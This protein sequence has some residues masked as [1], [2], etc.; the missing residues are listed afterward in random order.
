M[1]VVDAHQHFWSLPRGDYTWLTPEL[2]ALYRDYLPSDFEPLRERAGVRASVLIQAAASEAE[3]HYLFEIA[4]RHA[5]I[6]AVVGWVDFADAQAAER[7][8]VLT[9]AGQR[10]L[11]GLRPMIQ[12]MPDP[13]WVAGAQLDAAF[14][15]LVEHGLTFDALVK[16]R[17]FDA[18]LVRLQ[19]HPDLRTVIDHAGKPD[20]ANGGF[21]A[22][23]EG[24]AQIASTT[25]AFCK[26]SGLLTEAAAGASID[27]LDR[28]VAHVFNYFGA[29]RVIWGSDWPVLNLV[30]DYARWFALARELVQRHA[31]THADAVFGANAVRFYTLELP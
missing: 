22:W 6:A 2:G 17:H 4:H 5:C 11:K 28:Y 21:A 19:R 26:L 24:I 7:I 30:A 29:D 18:L 27:D 15:A 1:I 3:T 9:A 14:D 25:S 23:A 10:K 20:I 8:A 16:P 31:P 12:D 13:G